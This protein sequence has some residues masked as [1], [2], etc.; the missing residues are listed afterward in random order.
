MSYIGRH[1]CDFTALSYREPTKLSLRVC[2][3]IIAGT[4]LL[5]W[6]VVIEA[7]GVVL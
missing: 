2:L 7:F 5:L 3:L 6:F 4:S 1:R